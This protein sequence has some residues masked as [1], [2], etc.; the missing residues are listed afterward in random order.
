[1]EGRGVTTG[2]PPTRQEGMSLLSPGPA[3]P[4]V[5][6]HIWLFPSRVC[7]SYPK[8]TSDSPPPLPAPWLP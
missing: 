2:R 5:G 4:P 6:S 3:L 8:L 7:E 1:M